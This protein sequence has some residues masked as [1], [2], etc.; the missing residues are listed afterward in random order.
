MTQEAKK[1]IVRTANEF[2][3]G[4]GRSSDEMKSERLV[5]VLQDLEAGVLDMTE[6]VGKTEVYVKRH[7]EMSTSTVDYLL[8]MVIGDKELVQVMGKYYRALCSYLYTLSGSTSMN[9][10]VRCTEDTE[11]FLATHVL[12]RTA[13]TIAKEGVVKDKCKAWLKNE[14]IRYSSGPLLCTAG[15]IF[16]EDC[17]IQVL[18]TSLEEDLSSRLAE[19][20][21]CCDALRDTQRLQE[22]AIGRLESELEQGRAECEAF[23]ARLTTKHKREKADQIVRLE[24]ELEQGRAE[25]EALVARLT[26][27][28]KQAK[29]D[30][31]AQH[32]EN[33]K[34]E[35]NMESLSPL[36]LKELA[37]KYT[38][39]YHARLESELAKCTDAGL[40]NVCMEETKSIMIV[41]CNHLCMCPECASSVLK[42][43]PICPICRTP[44]TG[45]IRV[46]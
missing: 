7:T 11:W 6:E 13:T 35:V 39:A 28:H 9:I 23:V 15:L 38:D 2:H 36:A 4:G 31:K 45:T 44:A 3:N 21:A 18:T 34:R 22:R 20:Q 1:L 19:T 41:P 33:M 46:Y 30:Q 10:V 8:L 16:T 17:T 12:M 14:F 32:R 40:C 24:S 25:C 43:D 5:S 27:K 42:V 29:A 26:A 37:Q